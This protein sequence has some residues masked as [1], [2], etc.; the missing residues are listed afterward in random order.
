MWTTQRRTFMEQTA[1]TMYAPRSHAAMHPP[2]F[3]TRKEISLVADIRGPT[4]LI[5]TR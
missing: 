3:R 2:R 4:W 5:F 1:L